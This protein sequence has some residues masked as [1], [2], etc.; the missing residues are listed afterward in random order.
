MMDLRGWEK[1]WQYLQSFGY[2]TQTWGSDR[3]TDR[4]RPTAK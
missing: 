1:V 3:R 4:H 2:N